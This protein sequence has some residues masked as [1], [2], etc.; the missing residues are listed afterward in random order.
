MAVEIYSTTELKRRTRRRIEGQDAD[1]G[2]QH[3]Q[4]GTCTLNLDSEHVEQSKL[5]DGLD[6]LIRQYIRQFNR[7]TPRK[8]MIGAR[9]VGVEIQQLYEP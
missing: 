7:D 2:I 4:I 6:R 1:G 5:Q 8:K 9:V 3:C